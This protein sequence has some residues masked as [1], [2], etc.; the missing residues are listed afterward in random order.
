MSKSLR[1]TRDSQQ[2][3]TQQLYMPF[4][5]FWYTLSH[6]ILTR[7][8][9]SSVRNG[10]L[11]QWMKSVRLLTELKFPKVCTHLDTATVCT[12]LH[13]NT[14]ALSLGKYYSKKCNQT[15]TKLGPSEEGLM[16]V[17][18]KTAECSELGIGATHS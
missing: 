9:L 13:C 8:G 7:T 1:C 14:R 3:A 12:F 15:D 5:S 17:P 4:C 10:C 16:W 2:I 11:T 18:L 6:L